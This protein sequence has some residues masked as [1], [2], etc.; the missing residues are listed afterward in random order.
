MES[1]GGGVYLP[2]RVKRL[3]VGR[4]CARKHEA[5]YRT[6]V[7]TQRFVVLAVPMT[8]LYETLLQ[9]QGD[10][11]EPL[12]AVPLAVPGRVLPS[13]LQR[14]SS[15]IRSSWLLRNLTVRVGL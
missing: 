10:K 12:A 8:R 11:H 4:Q 13:Q 6:P 5:R 15:V 7:T 2:L 9:G 1:H 14:T 3:I